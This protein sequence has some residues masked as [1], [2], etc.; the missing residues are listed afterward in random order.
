MRLVSVRATVGLA[1]IEAWHLARSILV[2]A[3]FA[4][5]GLLVWLYTHGTQPTWWNGGWTIGYG[6]AALSA[7]VL[8][9]A[10]LA[11]GREHRDGMSDF[12][13]S[14]PA[15]TGRRTLALLIGLL[16]AI[17]AS[18]VLIA[19]VSAV[20][21]LHGVV[22]TPDPA[23]LAGGTLLVL[24]GGAIGVAI[25]RRFPHPLAGVLGALG[26]SIPFSQSNRIDGPLTWLLPWIIPAQLGALPGPLAGYPPTVAHAVEL[27]GIGLLAV[28][29]ALIAA[30]AVRRTRVGLLA[31]AAAAMAVIL[32][33][34]IVQ[35]RPVPAGDVQNLVTEVANI[36][37]AQS[38]TTTDP[39]R[40][41]LY[42][43][44]TAR[45]PLLESTANDVL[46]HA[47]AQPGRTL[48]IAQF[49]GLTL[50]DGI[51]TNGHSSDQV[52]AWNAQL[53]SAPANLASSSAIYL[54]LGEWPTGGQEADDARFDLALGVAEWAVGLPT[55]TGTGTGAGSDVLP[56]PCVPLNQAREA[57]A[58]WLGAQ[59]TALPPSPFHGTS[60]HITG[61]QFAYVNGSTV[62]T[63]IYPGEGHDFGDYLAS[64]GAQTTAAGYLLAQAMT[65]L[66]VDRVASVLSANWNSWTNP[67]TSDTQL[68][69][70]LD[71]TMPA[72]PTGVPGPHDQLL[73]PSPGS[74][75]PRAQCAT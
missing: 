56:A 32:A 12:Y 51:L 2:M 14:L 68:A 64:P 48:T 23:A 5:G 63:W 3:G 57:I 33:T 53:N 15:S 10:Q 34:G 31:V 73:T 66:P 74:I 59:A 17:P 60:T 43:A 27:A 6:Q 9:A 25:G 39:V 75:A 61:D 13:R 21:E 22:G 7:A 38:C 50:D 45:M 26:W 58:I 18:V 46:T 47:P 69:A 30:T 29:L 19:V 4:A 72:V 20:F 35:V 55:N 11:T 16:G 49:T 41:C 24:A 70:A 1:R 42:P 28:T 37:S 44:F 54:D 52:A 40:Y 62:V 36:G 67:Q 8:V 65:T 71:I